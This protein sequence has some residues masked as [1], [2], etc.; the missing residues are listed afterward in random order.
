TGIGSIYGS[1]Q[2]G[3]VSGPVNFYG[4]AL[5]A[6]SD[7]HYKYNWNWLNINATDVEGFWGAFVLNQSSITWNDDTTL[8]IGCSFIGFGVGN[9]F[10]G[11]GTAGDVQWIIGNDGA[12]GPQGDFF[13][14]APHFINPTGVNKTFRV[15]T[16]FSDLQQY[17][18][19]DATLTGQ[20]I[21]GYRWSPAFN[22]N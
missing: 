6:T 21:R 18:A 16:A 14:F 2:Q 22:T 19:D 15:I 12:G 9:I 10:G 4:I 11:S 1:T 5:N 8:G 17:T 13:I 7:P 3:D 20:H